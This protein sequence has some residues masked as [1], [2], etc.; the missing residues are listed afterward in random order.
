MQEAIDL[1]LHTI[2]TMK[3]GELNI[4]TLPAYR[5]GDLAEAM[6]AKMRITGLPAYEKPHESMSDTLRSDQARRMTIDELRS[7]LNAR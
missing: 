3:G 6:R 4:P 1:V 5:L 7:E 2:E